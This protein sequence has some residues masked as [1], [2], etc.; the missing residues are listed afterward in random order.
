MSGIDLFEL[1]SLG[2]RE[3]KGTWIPLDDIAAPGLWT[4]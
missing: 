4:G 2:K 1:L 3:T